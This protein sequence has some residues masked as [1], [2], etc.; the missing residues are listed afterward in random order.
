MTSEYLRTVRRDPVE[1]LRVVAYRWRAILFESEHLQPLVFGR[2]RELTDRFGLALAI[3]AVILARRDRRVW[4]VLAT[5]LFVALFGVGL[6]HYEA[7][8]VRYVQ[9]AYV[10]GALIVLE[11]VWLAAA[12]RMRRLTFIATT[13]VAVLAVVYAG[14]QLRGLHHAA[15]AAS[16]ARD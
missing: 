12:Q 11:R 6:V 2:A 8:Y 1:A 10:L 4:L 16:S 7:R 3:G 14:V 9:L 15:Q 5:P 13:A